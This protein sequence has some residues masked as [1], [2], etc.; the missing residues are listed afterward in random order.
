M[1][2]AFSS[3]IWHQPLCTGASSL[4]HMKS[5]PSPSAPALV[6]QTF[7]GHLA[8]GSGEHRGGIAET[9]GSRFVYLGEGTHRAG[10]APRRSV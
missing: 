6:T 10:A 2:S 5:S 7:T 9:Q 8:S 1:G 3:W 4:D